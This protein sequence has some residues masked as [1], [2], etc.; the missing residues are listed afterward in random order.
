MKVRHG[1]VSNSS[2]SSFICDVTSEERQG[3]DISLEDAGMYCCENEH[4]FLEEFLIGDIPEDKDDEYDGRYE[5]P[6]KHCPICSFKYLMESSMVLYI[7]K[8]YGITSNE[9]FDYMKSTNKRLRKLRPKYWFDY[10][11]KER[12]VS[13]LKLDEEIK[14][15]FNSVDEFETNLRGT[16]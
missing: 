1:F 11:E 12:G 16:K 14:A 3:M 7:E 5:I 10:L 15:K 13:K 4:Y 2:S 8:F 6:A 9:V